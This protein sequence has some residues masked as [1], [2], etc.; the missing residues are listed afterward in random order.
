MD[1][2][3]IITYGLLIVGFILFAVG[4]FVSIFVSEFVGKA[5]Q[6]IGTMMMIFGGL[7]LF[8]SLD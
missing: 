5:L 7:L 3:M 4:A 1:Y 2:Y 8:G 6:L